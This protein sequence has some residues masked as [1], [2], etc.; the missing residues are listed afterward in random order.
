MHY[1]GL[2]QQR[3]WVYQA[4]PTRRAGDRRWRLKER[5]V[6]EEEEE[7]ELRKYISMPDTIAP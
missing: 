3:V 5:D 2:Q 4:A 7:T 1:W 6:G